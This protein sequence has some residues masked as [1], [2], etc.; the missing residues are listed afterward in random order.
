MDT[1]I[2]PPSPNWHLN[3]ILACN[4]N[5]LLAYGSRGEVTIIDY[6]KG[7]KFT[8]KFLHLAHKEKLNCVVF[9]PLK[10]K[11]NNC[12]ATCGDDGMVR[13]WDYQ[14]LSLLLCHS[15]HK[16]S[17]LNKVPCLIP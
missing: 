14:K 5:G 17:S 6:K 13:L 12:L 1:I 16:V 15:G 11:F 8:T 4:D 9:S 7:N 2:L 10:G 3:R